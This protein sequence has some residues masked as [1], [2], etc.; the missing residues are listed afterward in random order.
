LTLSVLIMA[1]GTGGH[2][3]PGIATARELAARGV[4]VAWL[5]SRTGLENRLVPAAGIAL[6][7]IE[8]STL[9]GRGMWSLLRAPLHLARAVW[10]ALRILRRLRPNA[11][12]SLGG[13]AA[14]PGG[15][16][17]WLL[18]R[19]LL[20]HEQNRVPGMTNRILAKLARRVLCGFPDAFED[21]RAQMVGNPVR[22][23][24][25]ALPEPTLRSAGQ[26]SPLRLL[27]IGGS[28]GARALNRAVP[29][30]VRGLEGISVWHQCGEKCADEARRL[31]LEAGVDARIEPFIHAIAQAYAW[32]DLVIARAGALTIA[33]LAA[34]GCASILVPFPHAVDDHQTRNAEWLADLGAA[35]FIPESAALDECLRE[36]IVRLVADRSRLAAMAHA[37]RR[38]A[39]PEAAR[40][41]AQ[42]CIEEAMR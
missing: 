31:Y 27:V 25:A 22:A 17:A 8:V 41:V 28:Q 5:G 19:P 23:E 20:V 38:A 37:A 36:A 40:A 3:F 14:G 9:R 21:R 32:A 16:A 6:E 39:H 7:T 35:E 18:R 29:T 15:I 10:Q 42:A 30:A 26:H 33:E 13:F 11:V 1:G 12:L 4:G 34:A 24:I 2:I